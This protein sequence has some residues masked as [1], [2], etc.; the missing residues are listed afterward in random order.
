MAKEQG[1][2]KLWEKTNKNE[3]DIQNIVGR[4]GNIKIY[5]GE[6]EPI[7]GSRDATIETVI[8]SME[9]YSIARIVVQ[10][11]NNGVKPPSVSVG[12]TLLITKLNSFRVE[13]KFIEDVYS[14]NLRIFEGGYHGIAGFTGWKE[15]FTESSCPISKSPTGWAKFANGL[16]VQWGHTGGYEGFGAG[17]FTNKRIDVSL[18]ISFSSGNYAISGSESLGDDYASYKTKIQFSARSI[19]TFSI[20]YIKVDAS[21]STYINGVRWMAIGY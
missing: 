5:Y 20:G 21:P 12:G 13:I 1:I 19:S 16:I 3:H 8:K 2:P 7:F 11:D 4:S 15:V 17:E 18:P 14:P 6:L 9:E 10:S